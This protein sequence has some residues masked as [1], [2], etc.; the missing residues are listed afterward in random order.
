MLQILRSRCLSFSSY[1]NYRLLHNDI[2]I[3]NLGK[4]GRFLKTKIHIYVLA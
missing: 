2:K 1:S 3:L 4:K